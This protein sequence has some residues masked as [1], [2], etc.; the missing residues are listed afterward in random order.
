MK[1]DGRG[2]YPHSRS[3]RELFQ[4]PSRLNGPRHPHWVIEGEV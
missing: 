3:A 1:N 4:L 2:M